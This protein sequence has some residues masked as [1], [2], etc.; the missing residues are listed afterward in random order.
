MNGYSQWG[1]PGGRVAPSLVDTSWAGNDFR[2]GE[3][4]PYGR[5]S[6][7]EVAD[8]HGGRVPLHGRLF[9]QWMHLAY[10]ME[11]PFPHLAGATN[12]DKALE[13]AERTGQSATLDEPEM[14]QHIEKAPAHSA[15]GDSEEGVCGMWAM[16]EALVDG[17]TG[18]PAVQGRQ[19]KAGGVP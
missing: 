1:H 17:P 16:E 8:H 19:G 15:S 3:S 7:Q 10:P 11:C 5:C 12:P 14:W 13:W 4:R 9:A 2:Y 18:T 6:P